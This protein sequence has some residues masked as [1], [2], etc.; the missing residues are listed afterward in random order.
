MPLP[1][2]RAYVRQH[3]V[4]LIAL[5]LVLTGG[6]AYAVTAP[7]NSV[8]SSSIRNGAVKGVDIKD[9]TITGDDIKDGTITASDLAGN[10]VTETRVYNYSFGDNN[11]VWQ[12]PNIGKVTM[13]I[14][15]TSPNTLNSF[16]SLNVSPGKAGVYGMEDNNQ[17]GETGILVGAATVSRDSPG[18]PVGGAGFGGSGF[19]FGQL[20]FFYET[21]TKDIY[22]DIRVSICAA[23]GSITITH[24][25][26]DTTPPPRPAP[27]EKRNG[28]VSTGAAYCGAKPA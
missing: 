10:A 1:R 21:P 22:I 23:R 20:V 13:S 17:S 9:K 18:Q 19:G 5:M 3:H 2:L 26:P 28:C 6:T 4:G 25:S 14:A 24:K 8:V 12:D 11:V 27:G 15:C 16:A 7:K